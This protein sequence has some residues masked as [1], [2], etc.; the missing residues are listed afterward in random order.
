MIPI[1]LILFSF[2]TPRPLAVCPFD[3][4]GA[5]RTHNVRIAHAGVECQFHHVRFRLTSFGLVE[6]QHIFWAPCK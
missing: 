4:T 1:L 6:E 3:G 2:G 5:G